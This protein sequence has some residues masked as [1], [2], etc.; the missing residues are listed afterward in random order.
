MPTT[1]KELLRIAILQ[2]TQE[3]SEQTENH[4]AAKNK[5]ATGLSDAIH[6]YT[7]NGVNQ[8]TT[9]TNSGSGTIRQMT[10]KLT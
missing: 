3:L 2:L 6:N 10:V 9:L 8:Q 5:F 7:L 4:Q 1:N